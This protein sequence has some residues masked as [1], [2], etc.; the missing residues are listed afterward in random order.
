M[1]KRVLEEKEEFIKDV[2]KIKC[3]PN[4]LFLT[5]VILKEISHK[6][7]INTYKCGN[8]TRGYKLHLL[9]K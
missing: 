8:I 9:W 2:L 3:I 7:N 5:S 1:V 6:N 4:H